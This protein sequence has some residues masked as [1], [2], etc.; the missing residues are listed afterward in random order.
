[1]IKSQQI[2][3]LAQQGCH[4][5][6]AITN[7]QIDK[8]LRTGT[9]QLE[10]FEQELAEVL[11]EEDV[12]YVLRRNPVRAQE[13]RENRHATRATLQ[14]QVAK[15]NHYRTAPPRANAQGALQKLVAKAEQL[16]LADW[17]ELP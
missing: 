15:Q 14:A 7:P 12:R 4:S 1:M 2:D 6:T 16:R 13:V 3:D 5:I 17:V 8:L 10:L 11:A 9:F